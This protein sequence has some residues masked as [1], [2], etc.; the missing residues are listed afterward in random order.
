M[1]NITKS[2]HLGP[3]RA[4][5][6]YSSTGVKSFFWMSWNRSYRL[7]LINGKRLLTPTNKTR[8]GIEMSTPLEKKVQ[9]ST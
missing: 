1:K 3:D 2:V 6:N 7:V 8:T 5:S 9:H 4:Y